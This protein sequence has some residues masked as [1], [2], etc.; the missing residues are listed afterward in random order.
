MR[1]RP[2]ATAVLALAALGLAAALPSRAQPADGAALDPEVTAMRRWD[3][4]PYRLYRWSLPLD[5]TE[6]RVVDASMGRRLTRWVRRGASLVINGGFYGTDRQP[7]GLVVTR[8]REVSGFMRRIGGG[9]LTLVERRADLHDAE[10]EPLSLPA[11]PDFAIQCR[12][13]LVVD[14]AN[15]IRRRL[16]RTA[17]RTALCI[18]DGGRRLDVYLARRDPSRGRA[19]PT[20]YTLGQVLAARGC[21]QALN[22]DGGP[23]SGAAWR[24]RRGIRARPPRR[25]IRHAVAFRVRPVEPAE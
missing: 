4:E 6:V 20:L 1:P 15:N 11:R 8:G 17:A 2:R 21:E 16:P 23:S 18:R 10:A 14:G 7:E 24:G 3:G 12:P 22:L 5:R 9:V 13:R 25:G 19:G